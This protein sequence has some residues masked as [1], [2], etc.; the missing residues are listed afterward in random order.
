VHNGRTAPWNH[1]DIQEY[2][3][4]ALQQ[5]IAP[6]VKDWCDP[7][8]VVA[9]GDVDTE[10]RLL[11]KQRRADLIITA[12][13]SLGPLGTRGKPGTVFKIV[14]NADCPVLT[15]LGADPTCRPLLD[16]FRRRSCGYCIDCPNRRSSNPH[17]CRLTKTAGLLQ[18]F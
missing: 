1:D 3:E 14:A 9:F 17:T 13:H 16:D 7:E 18:Q 5:H 11:M 4:R 2:F 15:I 8:C 6:Q 10:I 12:A